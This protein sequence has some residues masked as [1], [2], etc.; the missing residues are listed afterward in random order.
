MAPESPLCSILPPSKCNHLQVPDSMG[1][2]PWSHAR[3]ANQNDSARYA[4]SRLLGARPVVHDASPLDAVW[5]S[6]PER[7]LRLEPCV[8]RRTVSGGTISVSGQAFTS[9]CNLASCRLHSTSYI[10]A[11]AGNSSRNTWSFSI[12]MSLS[13]ATLAS[14]TTARASMRWKPVCLTKDITML[15]AKASHSSRVTEHNHAAYVPM[16]IC[17]KP[18]YHAFSPS[19]SVYG[20]R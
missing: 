3:M 4:P 8:R 14:C 18:R 17:L 20:K 13:A 7:T 11:T 19:T 6:F 2:S 10:A 1:A 16:I 9:A 5:A 15:K 12:S